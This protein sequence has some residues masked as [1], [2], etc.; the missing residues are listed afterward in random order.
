MSVS[1][2]FQDT[3]FF[4]PTAL[5]A[6]GVTSTCVIADQNN[7]AGTAITFQVN[8]A[9]IGTNVIVRFE[10]SVDNTNFFAFASDTTITANGT[11]GYNFANFPVKAVRAR[12]VTITTGTPTVTFSIAAK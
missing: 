3:L 10:G 6:T 11:T 2:T 7:A 4:F 8:V 1:N 12:L 9:N 5:V